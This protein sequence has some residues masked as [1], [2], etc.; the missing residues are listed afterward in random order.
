M[1]V[2]STWSSTR[3]MVLEHALEHRAQI[4]CRLQIAVLVEIGLLAARPIS[5]DPATLERTAGEQ[6]H[7]CG[8]VIGS[9]I[10]V[11][12]RGAAELCDQS[13]HS[14]QAAPMLVSIAAIAASSIG[15]RAMILLPDERRQWPYR[16][17]FQNGMSSH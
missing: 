5:D 11:D 8:T 1:S 14:L 7:C 13:H 15:S 17:A 12:T 4:G 2:T 10:A 3:K 6:R 9:V 16:P